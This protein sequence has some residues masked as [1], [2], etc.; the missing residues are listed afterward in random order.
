MDWPLSGGPASAASPCFGRNGFQRWCSGLV[1]IASSVPS[2]IF[3][4]SSYEDAVVFCIGCFLELVDLAATQYCRNKGHTPAHA[5]LPPECWF[6]SSGS[7]DL[8]F[9]N[10]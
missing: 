9:P 6:R 7:R 8:F 1:G 4:I 3:P 5:G 10:T 2:S